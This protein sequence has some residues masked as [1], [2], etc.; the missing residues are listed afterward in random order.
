[1]SAAVASSMSSAPISERGV[2][3]E[4][5]Q[6]RRGDAARGSRSP[7]GARG[8]GCC[9][10][11][12]KKSWARSRTRSSASRS[13]PALVAGRAGRDQPLAVAHE[14]VE[15]VVAHRHAEILRRD[16]LEL[17]RLV[18]DRVAALRND[19]AVGALP[20]RRVGAQQMMI[21]DDQVRLGGALPHPRDEAVG[22]ARALGAD[23]VLRRGGDLAPERQ[24]LGKVRRSRRGRPS[25]SSAAHRSMIGQEDLRGRF[26]EQAAASRR[27][28][29][30]RNAS[31]R[32]RQR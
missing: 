9:A 22:V 2:F 6:R 21:D 5:L 17:V 30:S 24:V 27:A 23:A 1:M 16:V 7:A 29:A 13:S 20:D 32:C 31:K 18:D 26:A 14:L 3:V 8:H 28:A 15:P 19:L 25:R 11:F 4:R 10:T 12:L